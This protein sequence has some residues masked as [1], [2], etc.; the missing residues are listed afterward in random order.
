MPVIWERP[1]TQGKGLA[2]E[3]PGQNVLFMDGHVEF[4][5][6]DYAHKRFPVSSYSHSWLGARVPAP[7]GDADDP[8]GDC[9]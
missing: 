2:H 1:P 3:P 5:E 7:S 4:L 8:W 6:P 9:P